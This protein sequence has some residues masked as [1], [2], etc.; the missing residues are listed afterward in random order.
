MTATSKNWAHIAVQ[1]DSTHWLV[2][3]IHENGVVSTVLDSDDFIDVIL[4][5]AKS[6]TL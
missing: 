2:I 6:A 5:Q 1:L 3:F 4:D